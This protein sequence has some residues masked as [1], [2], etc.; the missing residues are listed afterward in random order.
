MSAQLTE[1]SMIECQRHGLRPP[2]VICQH[3]ERGR[4]LG[5]FQPDPDPDDPQS[6]IQ[7]AWCGHCDE[8]LEAEGDWTDRAQAF[9]APYCVCEGCLDDIRKRNLRK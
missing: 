8:V 6:F 5:F 2:A 4:D 3:L 1:N 9:A 7:H